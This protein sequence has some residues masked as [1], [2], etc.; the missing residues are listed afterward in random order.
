MNITEFFNLTVNSFRKKP[1]PILSF[2]SASLLGVSVSDIVKSAELQARGMKAIADRFD[3]LASVSMMDLSVEAEAFGCE[4]VFSENE[5][6]TVVKGAVFSNGDALSLKTPKTGDGRTGVYLDAV[7][8]AKMLI[9]DRPVFAGMIG[10]FSL[11]G[12]IIGVDNVMFD[13]YDEPKKVTAVLQKATEFLISYALAFK[14]SGADGVVI[15]EPLCGV[16]SPSLADEFSHPYVKEII[17]AVKSDEFAVIYHNCGASAEYMTESI[18]ELGATACHFGDALNLKEI[19]EKMPSDLPIM[20]NIS[21]GA[22][23]VGGTKESMTAAV[24]KLISE[25]G[26]HKNFI[27]SSGC[28]IPPH[29]IFENI[30]AFF[31]AANK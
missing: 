8:K 19:L 13:C 5:V 7:K 15:A 14:A 18:A 3:A 24:N 20:G 28:D 17:S 22:E 6:P 27:I 29:A 4:I 26:G 1:M 21:P 16:L 2:P 25:C 9:T 30:E 10:P 11:A 12:R 23:F 31:K